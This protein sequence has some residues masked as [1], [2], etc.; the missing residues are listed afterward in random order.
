MTIA[1]W[2]N[3]RRDHGGLI[4]IDLRDR[5]GLVQVVFNPEVSAGA[6]S[7]ADELRGEYVVKVCGRVSPRP[8]GT[9]NPKLGTGEIELIAEDV[10]IL[11]RAK[12]PPFYINEDIEV[13]DGDVADGAA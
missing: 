7:I 3:R 13:D 4:F 8:P 5:E 1:G 9:E 10:E 6:H 12:T 11:N 2:V